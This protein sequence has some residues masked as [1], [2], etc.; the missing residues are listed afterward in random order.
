MTELESN[1]RILLVA[2]RITEFR[3]CQLPIKTLLKP[4]S[5][6]IHVSL[7]TGTTISVIIDQWQQGLRKE[8]VKSHVFTSNL[9][10][11][12]PLRTLLCIKCQVIINTFVFRNNMVTVLPLFCN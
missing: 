5:Q 2:L 10:T 9:V 3:L 12:F 1:F 4:Y 11:V 7:Y 8:N 6:S